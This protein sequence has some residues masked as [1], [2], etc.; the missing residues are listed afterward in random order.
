MEFDVNF[1]SNRELI[2]AS[3]GGSGPEYGTFIALMNILESS[4]KI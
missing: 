4:I 1:C 2:K 3:I